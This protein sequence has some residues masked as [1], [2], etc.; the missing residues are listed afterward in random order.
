MKPSIKAKKGIKNIHINSSQ[1][2]SKKNGE[3]RIIKK[4]TIGFSQS[5]FIKSQFPNKIS[6]IKRLKPITAPMSPYLICRDSFFMIYIYQDAAVPDSQPHMAESPFH[7]VC[8][9]PPF[10]PVSRNPFPGA[11]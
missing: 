10:L 3:I 4:S 8:C 2:F 9:F 7:L 1:R 6:K 11:I 5:P